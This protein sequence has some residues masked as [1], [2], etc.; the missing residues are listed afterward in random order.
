MKE[1]KIRI[2]GKIKGKKGN[3][4]RKTGLLIILTLCVRK[5]EFICG[6]KTGADTLMIAYLN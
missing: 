1:N 6:F 3:S 5:F 4:R 2:K